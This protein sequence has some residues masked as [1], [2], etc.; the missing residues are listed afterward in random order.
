MSERRF[1]PENMA[2]LDS[3][4]RR[5][6]LPPER[7]VALLN[8]EDGDTVVDIGAGTGYFTLPAAKLTRGKVIALD[9]EPQMLEELQ[10]RAR[11]AGL[12]HI[13]S[14]LGEIERMPLPDGA[15]DHV[16][17]S[18]VLHE[19]EP[20][21]QGLK[22]IHRILKPGGRVLIAEWDVKKP[23]EGPPPAHRILSDD[24]L[25]AILQLGFKE[26]SVS[27][28]SEQYYVMTGMKA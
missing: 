11:E 22:E 19:V 15:A 28:P 12:S 18:L 9:A 25:H 14:Q 5:Q 4:E 27:F 1:N 24:L 6:S 7:L 3:P 10:K 21:E 16:I 13:Q 2:R 20:P 26:I 8:I 23:K 17:A